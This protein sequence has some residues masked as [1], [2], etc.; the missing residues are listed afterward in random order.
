MEVVSTIALVVP[1]PV[2]YRA[3][4]NPFL[5]LIE[6]FMLLSIKLL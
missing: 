5:A 2:V 3:P 4:Y 1:S 6:L